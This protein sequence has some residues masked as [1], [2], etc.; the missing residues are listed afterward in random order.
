MRTISKQDS[1]FLIGSLLSFPTV[2]FIFV[3]ILNELGYNYL[4]NSIWFKNGVIRN[5]LAGI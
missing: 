1:N 4:F 5:L 3:N 2:Y